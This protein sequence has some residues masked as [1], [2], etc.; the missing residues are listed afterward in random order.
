MKKSK[1]EIK[2]RYRLKKAVKDIILNHYETSYFLTITFNEET[3]QNTTKEKRFLIVRNYLN[4]QTD[5]YILNCDYG[6]KNER[7]HYHALT[8]AKDKYINLIDFNVKYGHIYPRPINL[9]KNQSKE[10]QI[11]IM[12][13]HF[14]KETS[15][16]IIHY[17]KAKR[18]NHKPK[19]ITYNNP[20]KNN[21]AYF[22]FIEQEQKEIEENERRLK[23]E[24]SQRLN[25]YINDFLSF[26]RR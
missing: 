11:N 5:K 21:R 20:N 18:P 9:N 7:E 10:S 15:E 12:L 24:E 13:N 14:L 4:N 2:R 16:G 26:K 22:K 25:K 17:S 23:E 8:I 1:A 19:K 3:L 6:A